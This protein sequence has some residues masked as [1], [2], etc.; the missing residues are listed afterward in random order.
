MEKDILENFL[1]GLPER[2]A[3]R[4]ATLD[5]KLKS[6]EEA[7]EAVL[8][9]ERRLK[10]RRRI[11][12]AESPRRFKED[13][14]SWR[15]PRDSYRR[16]V[17]PRSPSP[18]RRIYTRDRNT[19][20]SESEYGESP[21]RAT[22]MTLRKQRHSRSP[23]HSSEVS[24]FEE[25]PR[26]EVIDIYRY[27]CRN[28]STIGHNSDN[29]SKPRRSEDYQPRRRTEAARKTS[30]PK[31]MRKPLNSHRAHQTGDTMSGQDNNRR[32]TVRF[33]E[34]T[35]NAESRKHQPHVLGSRF[36]NWKKEK[37]NS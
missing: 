33:S 25:D 9:I 10:N 18:H 13:S 28:C 34:E 8:E 14:H 12:E 24:E 32:R 4:I 37:E 36:Q 7:Y 17:Y 31:P 20:G 29:C 23:G 2:V 15:S 6:L 19:S 16:D 3:W 5:R 35:R 21:T 26:K 11:R 22:A 27:Y 1:E 30:S